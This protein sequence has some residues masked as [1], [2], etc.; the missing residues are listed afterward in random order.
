MREGE[1]SRLLIKNC[2]VLQVDLGLP[3]VSLLTHY[4]ILVKNNRI[5]A[6]QPTGHADP[7][8]CQEV[9]AADGMIAMPGLINTHVHVPMVLFRGLAEDVSID[10]WFNEYIWPLESNLQEDDVYWGMMLG[11]AEMIRAGVTT[12]ADHYFYMHQAGRAVE[13]AGTRA[14]LGWAIFSSSGEAMIE[15]TADFAREW[16]GAANG[17]IRTIL[18]P[19]A[20]YTCSDDYLRACADKAKQLGLGIHIHAS[21]TMDQT[22]ASLAKTGLT[23]IQVLEQTGVLDVPTIIAHACGALPEDIELLARFQAGIA[24]APKTYLKLAMDLTP[25]QLC[26]QVGVPVGLAT[27]GAVSNNTLNLWESL[28]LMAMMQKDRARTPEVM[29][30][31]E[32]LYIA[33]RE[34]ARVIGMGDELGALE[35]GYLADI[36]L[37]DLSGLHHQPLHSVTAS[38]VYNT[39]IHDVHTVIVD[40]QIVMRN[41][42]LLTIDSA[43]VI[44]QANRAMERLAQ[45]QPDRRIQTY[46]P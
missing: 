43:E 23:P 9:I 20:P 33:T 3:Q 38:L 44:A 11:L 14:L 4:D 27:D 30:I 41:R 5:E 31:P 8:Q 17:R 7:S 39:E 42:E 6:I 28:R 34:S 16:Q 37:L 13:R 24:H 45:R 2:A 15:R 21:E 25:I 1:V 46:N 29:A 40:G 32:A 10:R 22:N 19:H 36:I 18:A 35:P 12:V 26:Q